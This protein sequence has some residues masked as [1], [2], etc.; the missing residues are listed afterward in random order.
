MAD[1][2]LGSVERVVKVALAIKTAV[3]TAKQNKKDCVEIG[4]LAA[5]VS[6][7]T[8]RLKEKTEVMEDPAMRDTLEAM[9]NCLDDALLLIDTCH[10]KCFLLRYLCASHVQ[11]A[12]PGT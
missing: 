10:G 6:S 11:A 12:A 9:A 1:I 7:H 4:K 8:E 5:H 2:T 3:E